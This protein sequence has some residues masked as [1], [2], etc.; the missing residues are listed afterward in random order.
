M[1][2]LS[3]RGGEGIE[4]LFDL[5]TTLRIQVVSYDETQARLAV[6]AFARNGK[7]IDAKARLNMGDCASY[8]LAR[9]LGVPLLCRP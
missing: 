3:R 6:E 1:V 8:A 5:T 7:G 2:M 4:A 9:N